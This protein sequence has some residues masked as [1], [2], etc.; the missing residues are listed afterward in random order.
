[1]AVL[2]FFI[3]LLFEVIFYGVGRILIPI[4]SLGRARA[5]TPKEAIYSSTV[6]HTRIDGK[7]VISGAFTMVFGIASLILLAI[8]AHYLHAA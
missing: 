6:I 5:E 4:V 7:V 8:L 3:P 1:M 2:E